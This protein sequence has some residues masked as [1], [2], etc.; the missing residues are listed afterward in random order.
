MQL[1]LAR[2]DHAIGRFGNT[3]VLRQ[4]ALGQRDHDAVRAGAGNPQ[5]DLVADCCRVVDP[6]VLHEPLRIRPRRHDDV[7]PK[8][9]NLDA[10]I[11][12]ERAQP[13][14]RG[15]REHE[16]EEPPKEGDPIRTTNMLYRVVQVM[17]CGLENDE[18]DAVIEAEWAAGPAQAY[19]T[20]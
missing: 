4:V 6:V 19:F 11:R 14:N 7:R 1:V 5:A 9:A 12:I 20:P 10:T 8:A 16:Q 13:V 17:P 3:G 15:G 18:F 2:L